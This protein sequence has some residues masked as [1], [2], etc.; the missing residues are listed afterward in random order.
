MLFTTT[1][2]HITCTRVVSDS[3]AVLWKL[4]YRLFVFT[5][6]IKSSYSA[7]RNTNII[8]MFVRIFVRLDCLWFHLGVTAVN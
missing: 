1:L 2:H 4:C 6:M 8:L 3:T 5:N 7:L